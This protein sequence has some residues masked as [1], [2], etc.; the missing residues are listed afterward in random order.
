MSRITSSVFPWLLLPSLAFLAPTPAASQGNAERPFVESIDVRVVNLEAVVVDRRGERVPGLGPGDFRLQVDQRQVP[1]AY[2]SEIFEGVTAAAA[3][4]ATSGVPGLRA[5]RPAGTSYLVFIDEY[6]VRAGD[7][8]RVLRQMLPQLERLGAADRMAVVAFNGRRI[9]MLSSWSRSPG[10]LERVFRQAME[11]PARGLL[12]DAEVRDLETDPLSPGAAPGSD[13]G[14]D[15]GFDSHFASQR[16]EE[17]LERVTLAVTAT[18]RSFARPPGRKVMLLL[19]GAWPHTFNSPFG[20]DPSRGGRILQPIHETANLLG[21]TLYPIDT[22]GARSAFPAADQAGVG[23]LGNIDY[24]EIETHTTFGVLA[25][26][27]GGRALL[28]GARLTAMERVIADTRSYYWLGFVPDWK[29]NDEGHAIRLE[30]VRPG[31]KVRT[32]ESFQD[33]S[34]EKEVSFQVESALMFGEL[35]G[36]HPLRLAFGQPVSQRRRLMIPLTLTI[37]MDGISMLAAAGG[38][39]EANLEL[40][41]AALDEGGHRNEIAVIP[42]RLFG[43]RPPRSGE[44]AIY[45][46]EVKLRRQGHDLVVSLHDPVSGAIYAAVKK[47][48]SSAARRGG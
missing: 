3:E 37:P 6:F 19:A 31:L 46:T 41:I 18:L 7:R 40:R 14:I 1:I 16:M 28:D 21:Y 45:E 44:H 27:T 4:P 10:E 30:V 35:P 48:G 38:G 11:R 36:A 26:A 2:F 34:R 5:G 47:L 8:D 22:A 29:G 13:P 42:V 9:D 32:R 17:K 33:L 23:T 43:D 24:N 15:S 20:P 39:Y 25:A 12:T